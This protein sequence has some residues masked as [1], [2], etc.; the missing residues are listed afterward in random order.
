LEVGPP[1]AEYELVT[2]DD[3]RAEIQQIV[4]HFVD[5]FTGFVYVGHS[6]LVRAVHRGVVHGWYESSIVGRTAWQ[7]F[8]ADGYSAAITE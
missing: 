5:H 4:V 1:L 8:Q 7:P 6:N 2:V 3:F